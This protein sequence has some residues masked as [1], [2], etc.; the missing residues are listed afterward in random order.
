[1]LAER[2]AVQRA[3]VIGEFRMSERYAAFTFCDRIVDHVPAKSARALFLIPE[4]IPGFP[5]SLVAEATGQL[6]AWVSMKH[7]EFRGRPVAA[8]AG[9]TRFFGAVAP[10]QTLELEVEV[11]SC[12]DEAVAY[13]GRACVD[14]RTVLELQDCVGPMLPQIEYDDPADLAR[15]FELLSGAGAPSGRFKGVSLPPLTVLSTDAT[16][17]RARLDVPIEAAFFGDHFPRRPVFPATLMLDRLISVA[18]DMLR[19]S[20][21]TSS[22]WYPVRTR[23]VKVRDFVLPGQSVELVA[24]LSGNEGSLARV[25]LSARVDE[26]TVA[27]ARAEFSTHPV[28]VA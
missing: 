26:R 21:P 11:E 7:I 18:S 10:G 1:M 23:N 6:A 4:G 24:E 5:P 12:D 13:S 2:E 22:S 3:S 25:A 20:T 14:G 15:Q 19:S 9:E 27:T 16:T 8:L 17:R 28:E